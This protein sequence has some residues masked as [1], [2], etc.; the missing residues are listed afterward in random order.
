LRGNM[1]KGGNTWCKKL[2]TKAKQHALKQKLGNEEGLLARCNGE[3]YANAQILD[4]RRAQ[5]AKY[6]NNAVIDGD[7]PDKPAPKPVPTME[8]VKASNGSVL[9]KF[10]APMKAGF[11]PRGFGKK[12]AERQVVRGF[13]LAR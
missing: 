5:L 8:Q 10:D 11:K 6:K 4:E 1:A 2:M 7:M 3:R 13:N 9:R 12:I